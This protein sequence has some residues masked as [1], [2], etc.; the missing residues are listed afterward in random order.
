MTECYILT[1]AKYH[2]V[3]KSCQNGDGT[4]QTGAEQG[5][6]MAF[7]DVSETVF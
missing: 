7:L 3:R 6:S 2:F 1:V 4:V 5:V